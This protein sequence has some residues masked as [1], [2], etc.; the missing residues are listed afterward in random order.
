MS[1]SLAASC[2]VPE[3]RPLRIPRSYPASPLLR[4]SPPSPPAWP[5]PHGSPVGRPTLHRR[6]FPCCVRRP[7]LHADAITPAELR[8]ACIVLFL[9]SGG[10]PANWR[11]SASALFVSRLAQHSLTFRPATSPSRHKRPFHQRL[12]RLRHLHHPSSCY[13][14]ERPLPDRTCTR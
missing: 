11:R 3:L 8:S 7:S 2:V 13:R 14:L 10:L 4:A 6:D 5:V 12:R 9:R 1:R